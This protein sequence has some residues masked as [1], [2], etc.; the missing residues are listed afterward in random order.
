MN[1][2]GIFVRGRLMCVCCLA[3]LLCCSLCA[4]LCLYLW[5]VL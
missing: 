1:S 2:S 5:L 4:C 3:S